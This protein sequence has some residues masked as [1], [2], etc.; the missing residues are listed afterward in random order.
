[1][2]PVMTG[3]RTPAADP[4]VFVIPSSVPAKFGA[5]SWWEQR[6]PQLALPLRPTAMH[7]TIMA[8]VV[9]Q[10]TKHINIRPTIGP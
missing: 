6:K 1:M 5:S 7:R 3:A 9:L 2:L 4:T 8:S 10:L